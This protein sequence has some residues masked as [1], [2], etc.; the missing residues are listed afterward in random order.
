V[1]LDRYAARGTNAAPGVALR[2]VPVLPPGTGAK[3][4]YEL[5]IGLVLVGTLTIGLLLAFWLHTSRL[6]TPGSW[7]PYTPAQTR[8]AY[9]I[10]PL[11][12]QG[13]DGRGRTVVIYEL[14]QPAIAV[15][16]SNI[17]QDLAAYDRLFHLPQVSL[18]V[19]A[20]FAR[21]TAPE[22]ADFEEVMD[23][24]IVHAVA[25]GA[26]IQVLLV[27]QKNILEALEFAATNQLGDV[28]SMSMGF[29]E[30]CASSAGV[31][32]LHR[33]I[34]LAAARGITV[35]ASSGDSGVVPY[36]CR[37]AKSASPAAGLS[38]PAADPLVTAVGGTRLTVHTPSGRYGGETAWN[39][40]PG[41]KPSPLKAHSNNPTP[42]YLDPFS[43]AAHSSASG[44]GFS[45]RFPRP[46]YQ[47]GGSAGAGGRGVP[48]VAADADPETGFAII[49]VNANRP[50]VLGGGGTSAGA[51]LWAGLAALAD[52]EAGRRLG[53]LNP[54]IYRIAESPQ[55]DSAFHDVTDGNNSV[56]FPSG[57]V[58]G[59]QAGPGW[60]PVTGWG[61]PN[62][63][64]L[65]P[66]LAH[67]G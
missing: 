37:S 64:V 46:D 40:P 28:I 26:H 42:V 63:A 9:N 25:P 21:T 12:D 29:G 51:P 11:L 17:Y 45:K 19:D 3:P 20:R 50:F 48:D 33:V 10:A 49:Y 41:P 36:P 62:A 5:A 15:R 52:Q 56:L 47:G 59:Y 18:T 32:A 6:L 31:S 22:L 54:A 65:V 1:E 4:R 27:D 14:A 55:Y 58:H 57:P 44:G 43:G 24:E 60:D 7:S 34:E 16:H 2:T 8:V 53:P 13:I 38:L 23:A 30:Q 35:V 39:T 67:T 66:L 61:S